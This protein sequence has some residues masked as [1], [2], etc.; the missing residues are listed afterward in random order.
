MRIKRILIAIALLF[1]FSALVLAPSAVYAADSKGAVC[2]GISQTGGSCDNS[3]GPN[4]DDILKLLLNA[5]SFIIGFAA[6]IMIMVG[7]FK[8]ITS[9]GDS[10]KVASAKD[11]ILYSIIGLVVV[12]LAQI[13]VRFVLNKV[14]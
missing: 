4:L 8:Y 10:A 14:K 9:A 13:I 6:V 11:T 3:A 7:G 12:A 5:L 2:E 1:N